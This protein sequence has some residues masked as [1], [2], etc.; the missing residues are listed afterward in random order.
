MQCCPV[1][2]MQCCLHCLHAMLSPL[3]TYSVPSFFLNIVLSP[4]FT[5]IVVSIVYIQCCLHYLHAM[6]SPLLT[7]NIVSCKQAQSGHLLW[8]LCYIHT[9]SGKRDYYHVMSSLFW[10]TIDCTPH[11]LHFFTR[12][13]ISML[14]WRRWGV[15]IHSMF[16]WHSKG[17]NC[18]YKLREQLNGLSHMELWHSWSHL[19][20]QYWF[21]NSPCKLNLQVV[22]STLGESQETLC[23]NLDAYNT[24]FIARVALVACIHNS[25]PWN[26]C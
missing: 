2:Y 17:K 12:T 25:W 20:S 18:G 13:T 21:L 23:Q 19:A 6:L 14:W 7:Y 16:W 24:N 15:L 10:Y 3:F 5:C 22:S 11:L 8:L 1:V 9:A 4:L 26:V